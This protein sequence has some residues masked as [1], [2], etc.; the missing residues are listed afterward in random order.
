MSDNPNLPKIVDGVIQHGNGAQELNFSTARRIDFRANRALVERLRREQ[1][2]K[3]AE[4]REKAPDVWQEYVDA[5]G[6]YLEEG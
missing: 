5:L 6:D 2:E 1:E 4:R 3:N